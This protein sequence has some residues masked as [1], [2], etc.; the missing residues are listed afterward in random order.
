M[1]NETRSDTSDAETMERSGAAIPA[2]VRA[3]VREIVLRKLGV[4]LIAILGLVLLVQAISLGVL[5]R[6]RPS[7]VYVPDADFVRPI[8]VR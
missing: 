6:R 1:R 7:A 8:E 5:L 3:A 4:V 2:A